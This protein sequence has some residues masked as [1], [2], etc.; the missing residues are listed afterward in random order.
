MH[1][2]F[3]GTQDNN[4]ISKGLQRRWLLIIIISADDNDGI[5]QCWNIITLY[6]HKSIFIQFLSNPAQ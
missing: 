1:N 2:V 5:L 3:H 4:D 6:V